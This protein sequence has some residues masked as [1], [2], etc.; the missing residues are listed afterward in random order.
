[1]N[2]SD[3]PIRFVEANG[4]RFAYFQWGEQ[5]APLVLMMHG[6]PDSPHTWDVIGPAIAA[7]TASLD[8]AVIPG[9]H[10]C[11][12]ESPALMIPRLISHLAGARP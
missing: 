5:Q 9:G 8:I 1:M 4:I 6:F 7:R 12:R 10:F 2:P 3:S 11:H